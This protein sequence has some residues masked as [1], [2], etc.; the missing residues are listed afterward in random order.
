MKTNH[1]RQFKDT[2]APRA[3]FA[4]YI[5]YSEARFLPLSGKMIA[6]GCTSGDHTNGK[7]GIAKDR[8]GAKRYLNSRTRCNENM[9]LQKIVKNYCEEPE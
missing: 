8:R 3:I 6:A 2:R 5:P 4:K 7:R 9:A 1:N